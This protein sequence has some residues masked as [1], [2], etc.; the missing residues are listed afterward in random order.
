MALS[1]PPA[2]DTPRKRLAFLLRV[3]R[4]LILRHQQ[5][6]RQLPETLAAEQARQFKQWE[7]ERWTPRVKRCHALIEQYRAAAQ[8]A[9]DMHALKLEQQTDMTWDSAIDTE[10]V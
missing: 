7:R 2:A 8:D 4:R 10:A 5:V 1:F 9:D 6:R 3:H